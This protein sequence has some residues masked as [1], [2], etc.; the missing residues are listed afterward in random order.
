MPEGGTLTLR[1]RNHRSATQSVPVG[2]HPVSGEFLEVEVRD[3]GSG[4]PPELMTRIWEPFFTTKGEGKGTGLGLSTVAGIVA[5]H[6]GFAT[7]DS[8]VGEGSV[9]RVFLPAVVDREAEGGNSQ[10]PFLPRGNG[11]LI[12]VVDDDANVRESIVAL[13]TQ[14]GYRVMTMTDGIEA[15][16][17]Y[18][19]RAQEVSLIVTD[20]DMPHL[21]G[22]ALGGAIRRVNPAARILFISGTASPQTAE[23]IVSA[24]GAT[25]L[26]KPFTPEALLT[27]VHRL[28]SSR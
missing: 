8:K 13:L 12:F 20:I 1:A 25:L 24:L 10:H 3:T 15:L 17:Q 7:V 22:R 4:I 6:G 28:L 16:A 27:T 19:V 2:P 18:A 21:D 26:P 14:Q 9:F 11:E 5:S 23:R